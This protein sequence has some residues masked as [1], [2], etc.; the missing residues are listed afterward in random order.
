MF[1]RKGTKGLLV[2]VVIAILLAALLVLVVYNRS[3]FLGAF[4]PLAPAPPPKNTCCVCLFEEAPEC[5]TYLTKE[6]CEGTQCSD[7]TDND[8]DTLIDSKD[9]ECKDEL[10]TYWSYDDDESQ[11]GVQSAENR[12]CMWDGSECKNKWEV[13]CYEWLEGQCTDTVDN[14]GDSLIDSKDLNCT[15]PKKSECDVD[16]VTPR[17]KWPDKTFLQQCDSV[18]IADF[19]HGSAQDCRTYIMGCLECLT[20]KC[21]TVLASHMG[22]SVFQNM[23]EVMKWTQY[24]QNL[25]IPDETVFISGQQTLTSPECTTTVTVYVTSQKITVTLPPCHK[26][27]DFCYTTIPPSSV[28]CTD[29]AGN[30]AQEICCPRAGGKPGWKRG[31]SC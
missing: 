10:G 28:A 14:D 29:E 26:E 18:A 17:S 6:E 23:Q 1:E 22:C 24:L 19:G 4:V 20:P 3:A 11:P 9:P 31:S 15:V 7:G 25:L 16:L 30:P 8:G 21:H 2:C 5:S 13:R 12:N 27:G